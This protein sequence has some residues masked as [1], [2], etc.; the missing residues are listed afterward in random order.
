MEFEEKNLLPLTR[1][2]VNA[3]ASEKMLESGS[4]GDAWRYIHEVTAAVH[5]DKSLAW[6]KTTLNRAANDANINPAKRNSTL[7][8]QVN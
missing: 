7:L 8:F 5:A 4:I 1:E 2:E 6:V 3:Q